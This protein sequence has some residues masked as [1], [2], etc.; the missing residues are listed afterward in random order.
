M[1]FEPIKRLKLKIQNLEDKI[2]GVEMNNDD[3]E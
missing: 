1:E 3:E 2:K